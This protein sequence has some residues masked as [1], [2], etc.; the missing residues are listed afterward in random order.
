VKKQIP[1]IQIPSSSLIEVSA[2]GF[3]ICCPAARIMIV[4]T[5]TRGDVLPFIALAHGLLARGHAVRIATSAKHEELIRGAGIDYVHVRPDTSRRKRPE[6]ERGNVPTFE[7]M[8]TELIA[9][10]IA[11]GHADLVAACRDGACD[12]LLSSLSPIAPMAAETLGIPWIPATLQ[13]IVF[14]SASDPPVLPRL[15]WLAPLRRFGRLHG[16]PLRAVARAA[17]RNTTRSFAAARRAMG[18]LPA[19][20]PL[21]NWA[22]PPPFCLALF[23]PDLAAGQADWLGGA[24]PT[25]FC[26]WQY[27]TVPPEVDAFL[28]EGPPPL[29]VSLGSSMVKNTVLPTRIHSAAI[30]AVE[31][32]GMRCLL[33]VGTEANMASLPAPLPPGCLAVIGAPHALVFPRAAAILHHGGAGTTGE[34]MRAGR[35][36]LVT[37]FALDQFDNAARMVRSGVAASRAARSVNTASLKAMLQRILEPG[38]IARS[39]ALGARV[40]AEDGVGAACDVI[41]DWLRLSPPRSSQ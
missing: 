16:V 32:A 8:L 3:G 2:V 28:N 4:T 22:V 7:R 24:R 26:R 31:H 17:L 27:G 25:G 20:D 6:K 33:L 12:L 10:G 13:P 11:E 36:M 35:P 15:G 14:L 37:P 39:T 18:L 30:Q 34:A 21:L 38:V 29:V 23:S 5:G 19:S 40:R 41:E 9:P 1:N